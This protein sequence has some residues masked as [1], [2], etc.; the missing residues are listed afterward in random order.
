MTS[1]CAASFIM[2]EGKWL[3]FTAVFRH[4]LRKFAHLAT[5]LV[6]DIATALRSR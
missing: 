1:R 5:G 2:L 6:S 4:E 3:L